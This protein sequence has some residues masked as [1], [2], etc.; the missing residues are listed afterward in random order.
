LTDAEVI[1][2][3]WD[4]DPAAVAMTAN[5]YGNYCYSIA[6]SILNNGEDSEE[7]VNDTWHRAWNAMPPN[8]PNKL[9]LFLG[10][11]AR[12]LAFDKYR[13]SRAQKRGGS[14]VT[15]VLDE[16]N[17]CVPISDPIDKIVEDNELEQLINRFLRNLP[18]RECNI[19][20]LRYWYNTPLAEI[21][22]RFSVNENNVKSSLFRSRKKLKAYIE[23]EGVNL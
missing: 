3:Y 9:S 1:K 17:E 18:E 4:R 13:M 5:L 7:C 11:I 21:G 14:E 2:L 16:L 12:N 19:F 8:R 15:L 20:L 6:Y 22:K 10:K 23:K